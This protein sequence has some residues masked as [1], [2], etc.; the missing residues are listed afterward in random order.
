MGLAR[1]V[2]LVYVLFELGKLDLVSLNLGWLDW[3]GFVMISYVCLELIMLV[4]V[5]ISLGCQIG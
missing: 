2:S 4:L 3:L 1:L 5:R